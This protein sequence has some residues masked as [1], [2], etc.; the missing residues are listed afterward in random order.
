MTLIFILYP[1]F[2]TLA[3]SQQHLQF[4]PFLPPPNTI[5]DQINND[6]LN[7]ST[8]SVSSVNSNSSSTDKAVI[9]DFYD[10]DIGQ[11]TYAKPIL[12]KYGFKGTFF[13]VCNWASSN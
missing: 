2:P 5:E 6:I 10:N 12:D 4:F 8:T 13:I 3:H 7:E 1:L 9:L 11:F